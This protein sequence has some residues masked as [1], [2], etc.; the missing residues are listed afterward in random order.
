MV[1]LCRCGSWQYPVCVVFVHRIV[2]SLS[3]RI[4]QYGR[5]HKIKIINEKNKEFNFI[6]PSHIRSFSSCS[7]FPFAW[8]RSFE[9]RVFHWF[10][11]SKNE[12]HITCTVA[13][14]LSSVWVGVARTREFIQFS[15]CLISFWHCRTVFSV[16]L[17]FSSP[18]FSVFI[19]SF[20]IFLH[21]HVSC[22][23]N[24]DSCMSFDYIFSLIFHF[25]LSKPK[26]KSLNL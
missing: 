19:I 5:K 21:F 11:R 22:V 2:R 15:Y 23:S 12:P 17:F 14:S 4:A 20:S 13:R 9:W 26:K 8:T 7:F 18:S 6:A 10:L 16:A 24:D 1:F 3:K 25:A